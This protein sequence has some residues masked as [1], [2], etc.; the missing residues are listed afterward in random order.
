MQ[1]ILS[2]VPLVI[3]ARYYYYIYTTY[4]TDITYTHTMR[5]FPKRTKMYEEAKVHITGRQLN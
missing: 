2:R 5:K 3:K 4:Y 1:K